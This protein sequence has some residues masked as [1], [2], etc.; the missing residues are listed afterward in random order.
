MSSVFRT[1]GVVGRSRQQGLGE[2]LAELLRSLTDAGAAVMLEDR[3]RGLVQGDYPLHER[4]AI[5]A[6]ADLVIVLGG[7]G[8]MLS[9]ARA[10][11]Q[12][13]LSRQLA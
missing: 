9:A 7:D 3:F 11:L 5:G 8:S 6:G 4:E 12:R 2:V 10:L 1:V 13:S